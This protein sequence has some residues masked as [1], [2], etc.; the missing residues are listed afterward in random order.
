LQSVWLETFSV[1][2]ELMVRVRVR[3]RVADLCGWSPSVFG[4]RVY[5]QPVRGVSTEKNAIDHTHARASSGAKAWEPMA[6]SSGDFCRKTRTALLIHPRILGW[7]AMG[8]WL[9]EGKEH[10]AVSSSIFF[11]GQGLQCL[12]RI[13]GWGW[14]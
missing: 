14:G 1:W 6:S 3:V 7:V 12:D 4:R 11:F 8:C 10:H 13:D 2:T 9:V 5:C